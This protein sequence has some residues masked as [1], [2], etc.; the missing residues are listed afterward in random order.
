[1]KDGETS[2]RL[3]RNEIFCGFKPDE[4]NP[5]PKARPLIVT[6]FHAQISP[7]Y[8]DSFFPLY[9]RTCVLGAICKTNATQQIE[10]KDLFFRYP[11]IRSNGNMYINERIPL[12]T[13]K[14]EFYVED[15]KNN[16]KPFELFNISS[17]SL[18]VY[19][20][21]DFSNDNDVESFVTLGIE[22]KLHYSDASTDN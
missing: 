12:N 7:V 13:L 20:V 19:F 15:Q 4:S 2:Y 8:L 11:V 5:D 3:T 18:M 9:D 21:V 16:D 14:T 10:S 6:S 17:G 22:W 1:M